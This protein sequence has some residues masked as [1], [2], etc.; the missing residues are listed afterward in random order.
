M[1]LGASMMSRWQ[2]LLTQIGRRIW[3]RAALFSLLAVVT[4]FLGVAFS[5]YISDDLQARIGADA[6][7]HI[8][9]ILAASMLSVTT[10]S[11]GIMVSAYSTA[12]NNV[13]PLA[14]Q[15][16]MQDATTQNVLSTFIGSFLYSLVSIIVLSTGAYG[17]HGR[18]ILFAVTI[19]VIILII[20]TLLRWIDHLSHLGH[21]TETTAQVEHAVLAAMRRWKTH[22]CSSHSQTPPPAGQATFIFGAR[23]GYVQHI[24]VKTLAKLAKS[25]SAPIYVAVL[26]GAFV[27]P[28][29]PL[30]WM[31]TPVSD[32]DADQIRACFAI[33]DT[34]SFDQDPRFGVSVLAEIASRAL[35]PGVNDAGTAIDVIGRAVRIFAAWADSSEDGRGDLTQ[36]VV[37]PELCDADLFDDIFIPIA[38]DGAGVVEIGIR[39]QKAYRA[40]GQM[41][42]GGR[43]VREAARHA[44]MTL[45]RAEAALAIEED[46]ARIR[47]LARQ[48]LAIQA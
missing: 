22:G 24:D 8:L 11:L 47:E 34:R 14:T 4:A 28:A 21:V 41:Q 48:T 30:A 16:I 35:S 6:V 26:P 45:T 29:E 15:L 10:F 37:L 1:D 31:S 36:D 20:V 7:D 42:G 12:T 9:G 43:F 17:D 23:I 32:K 5:P 18:V 38:R 39:L 46:R 33:E 19:A 25:A 2:W 13:T 27:T 40:L 3:V 44:G